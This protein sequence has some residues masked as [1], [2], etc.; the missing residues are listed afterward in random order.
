M[1]HF[2]CCNLN[3]AVWVFGKA[4]FWYAVKKIYKVEM[5]SVRFGLSS[6]GIRP[7]LRIVGVVILAA[8]IGLAALFGLLKPIK[9]GCTMTYMYPTYIP[10]SVTDN[11]PSGR[12]GLYLYH[13]GWRKIDFKEHLQKLS[14]VPVLFI[15]GNAGSY[16][17]VRIL[18]FLIEFPKTRNNLFIVILYD[19]NGP[20]IKSIGY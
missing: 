7:R 3:M 1:F 4:G 8:W 10:I 2:F 6:Q 20:I 14:G 12:Y 5:W 16:K 15:P 19:L 13:E 11:A 17:Q 18:L 9:N